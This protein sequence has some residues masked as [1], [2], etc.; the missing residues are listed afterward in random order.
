MDRIVGIIISITF[1][2]ALTVNVAAQSRP[3]APSPSDSKAIERLFEAWNSR[4]AEKVVAAF[5]NAAVYEDV[6]AGQIHNGRDE[7]RKWVA[8]AFRDIGDFKLK[9]VRSTYYKRG[10]LVEWIWSGTDKGLFKT[11]KTFSV[12]GVSVIEVRRG[13]VSLYKEYYDFGTVMR[14]L[15]L[16]PPEKR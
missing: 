16:L 10:G 15:E 2:S 12:R 8:G 4:D 13:K 1:F 5:D 6:A 11:G 7:I 9:V 14:Q 3:E